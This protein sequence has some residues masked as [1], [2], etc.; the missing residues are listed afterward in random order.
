M[1]QLVAWDGGNGYTGT[2]S[3]SCSGAPVGSVCLVSPATVNI[4]LNGAPFTAT[5]TTTGKST[6]LLMIGT[7]SPVCVAG[8]LIFGLTIVPRKKR[9][10]LRV[11][12]CL[13]LLSLSIFGCGGG[14][15][16]S[17]PPPPPTPSGTYYLTVS[18]AAGGAQTSYLLT[19]NVN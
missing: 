5:V 4:G 1:Y 3:L 12:V 11:L 15:S 7:K 8:L 13:G 2:A 6:A 9:R 14:A 10:S 16:G 17:A 18:A 19:L